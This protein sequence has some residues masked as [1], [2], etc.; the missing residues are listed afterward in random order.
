MLILALAPMARVLAAPEPAPVVV[1]PPS[2][3]SGVV[4]SVEVHGDHVELD[5]DNK[6]LAVTGNVTITVAT[7]KPG[8]P[9]VSLAADQLEGDLKA[10]RM[11]A[12]HGVKLRSQ[13]LGLR[14]ER[15]DLD[16]KNGTFTLDRGAMEVAVPSVQAPGKIV[17]G[18]FFGNQMGREGRV[19]YVIEGR[20]TTCDRAKPHYTIGSKK[21][22]FDT[23]T[24]ALDV[25][26]GR[27]Q[28]YNFRLN[29]PGHFHGTLGGGG[30]DGSLALPLPRYS[31]FDGLYTDLRRDLTKPDADWSL[32][33]IL[34]VGTKLRFPAALVTEHKT[35]DSTTR[36]AATRQEEVVFN[37]RER[38]R[39]SRLPEV[40]YVKDLIST[41][42]GLPR[43]QFLAFGGHIR[44]HVDNL[45]V[46]SATR[47][48]VAL[49]YTPYPWQR[50]NRRGVWWAAGARQTFYDTGDQL[51]DVALELGTGWHFTDTLSA[52]VSEIHHFTSGESPFF[53]DNVWVE[54]EL[55]G[56]LDTA[57]ARNWRFR[58]T[59]R[60]DL[61]RG[62]LRDYTLMFSRRMHCL[63][64]NLGYS[65]GAELFSVGLDING[66][67][68]GTA[69][70]DTAPLVSPDEVPPLPAPV[71]GDA[72]ASP[73]PFQFMP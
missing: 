28:L 51:S 62:E 11:V 17:R 19:M 44:E 45:P 65:F 34:R 25:Y 21:V 4:L 20:I 36:I 37:L 22:T 5:D 40:S 3:L 26:G 29:I 66:V 9:T 16:F 61:D 69:P 48:G 49:D 56:T 32:Y 59:G 50:R 47:A 23:A 63:T 67:T 30:G 38:S 68:G 15:V 46:I 64:W 18:F 35:E 41:S 73:S 8:Y 39:I 52:S 43:L 58:G 70:P 13:Q 1:V 53:F 72:T 24:G 10:G 2:A 14:G 7:D 55:V 12:T 31:S 33:G 6:T 71:P 42:A 54:D 57:L 27:L 60:W